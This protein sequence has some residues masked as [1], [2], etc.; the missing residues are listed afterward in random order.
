M[1]E[2]FHHFNWWIS[3]SSGRDLAS[4]YWQ[5]MGSSAVQ[6]QVP[7]LGMAPSQQPCKSQLPTSSAP[8][9]HW[10]QHGLP[11]EVVT[12]ACYYRSTNRN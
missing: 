2:Q 7:Y 11:C 12:T 9:E 5:E 1:E 4:L 10:E 6:Q 8:N 3:N